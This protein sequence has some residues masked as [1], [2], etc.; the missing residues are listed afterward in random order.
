MAFIL[1]TT[2]VC[3][4]YA[5]SPTEVVP[6]V[7]TA[8][9]VYSSFNKVVNW[10]SELYKD[11][12]EQVE[13]EETQV[14][15]QRRQIR[16]EVKEIKISLDPVK[17]VPLYNQLDYPHVQYG[18]CGTVASHGC[19]VTSLAMVASY[20]LDEEL[21]P[22][23]MAKQFGKYNTDEG[24]YWILFEDSA[25]ELGLGF[26]ERTDNTN[27][28][29][30][31]LE[32]GQ[33]VIALQ[34]AGLFTG[35]GHFIVLV[36]LTDDGKIIVND[37]NGANYTKNNTMVEGF[38]NGFTPRQVFQDGVQYW[39]YDKK[40]AKNIE[41]SGNTNMIKENTLVLNINQ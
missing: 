25:V 7:E 40:E 3:P 14:R 17:S 28:V 31:A 23:E 18:C 13:I 35:G 21:F 16:N 34:H 33:V 1:A 22:D 29:M 37:P 15:I 11:Y 26:Q 19:G 32:N 5:Q 10:M 41:I 6:G 12:Q 38:T 20:L 8:S 36:D 27:T 9:T 2:S 4:A 39:I 30:K 24:S